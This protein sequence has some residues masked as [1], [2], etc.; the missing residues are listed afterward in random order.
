MPNLTHRFRILLIQIGKVLPFVVCGLIMISYAET[1]FSL[2]TSD[3]V[4]WDGYL[5]PNKHFSWLVGDYIEYN[6]QSLV[7]LVIISI[8]TETCIYNR[9]AC[10][11]LG[12]NLWE[13]HFLDFELEPTYVYIICIANIIIASYLTYKGIKILVST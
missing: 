4:V 7:V 5:I 9:L 1:A 6:L 2:A 8:A 11:Y 10:G 3:F 12:V 13:K